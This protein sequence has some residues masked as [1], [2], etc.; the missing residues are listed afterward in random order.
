MTT[1]PGRALVRMFAA[2]ALT[3]L[4]AAAFAQRGA[5]PPAAKEAAPTTAT[6][7]AAS[8]DLAPLP[9]KLPAPLFVGTPSR[10][11][12]PNMEIP[13]GKL[14]GPFMAP[15]G[16]VNLAADKPVTSSLKDTIIGKF[17]Q[18]TDGD[19]EGSEGS[20]IELD[21]GKQWVQIDLG[22]ES[23][24][25][26]IV[27]WHFHAGARIYKSVAVQV[28][29][30]PEFAK[31]ATTLFNNDIDNSLGLGAGKDKNYVETF[32]GRLVEA[33]SVHARYVRL[34]SNGNT[35]DEL[36]HYTEVEVYGQAAK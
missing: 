13:T 22:Q 6:A 1:L 4:S 14:R 24:L 9:I 36:N 8:G 11:S 7:T 5:A 18:I 17:S 34:Y 2:L 21:P 32:E 25:Y 30:D 27:V 3:T 15:K 28:S 16:A 33:K 19:K 12:V 35:S 31:G 10:A 23:E 26:A 29:D 20:Y